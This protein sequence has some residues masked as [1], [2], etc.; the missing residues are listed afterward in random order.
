M[1]IR[2]T[3]EFNTLSVLR[4]T[5]FDD[6]P[7]IIGAGVR[8]R[9]CAR[10]RLAPGISAGRPSVLLFRR[11]VTASALAR[12]LW[13]LRRYQSFPLLKRVECAGRIKRGK[14]YEPEVPIKVREWI[15][16]ALASPDLVLDA[17][18]P[19]Q[20]HSG[21]GV[22]RP[23]RFGDGAYFEVVRPSA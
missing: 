2:R 8:S 19:A 16:P 9:R 22:S 6:A 23:V 12:P 17:Q 10:P 15:G 4:A 7:P 20:P 5:H 13:R 21:V 18:P 3:E 1:I 11:H 14:A